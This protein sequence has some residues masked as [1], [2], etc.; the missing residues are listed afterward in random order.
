MDEIYKVCGLFS[1]FAPTRISIGGQTIKNNYCKAA[2][3]REKH[4]KIFSKTEK[5]MNRWMADLQFYI[6]F[7]SISVISGGWVDDKE[8]L[9]AMERCLQLR[10]FFLKLGLNPG[11]LDQQARA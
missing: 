8:R 5:V 10:R 11:L 7:N 9:C 6:L 3:V 4:L 2:V 1:P